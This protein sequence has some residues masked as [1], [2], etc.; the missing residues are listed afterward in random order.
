[1][2][3]RQ[4]K[5]QGLIS[6]YASEHFEVGVGFGGRDGQEYPLMSYPKESGRP[7]P[8]RLTFLTIGKPLIRV[9]D[10]YFRTLA[11]NGTPST[12][13]ARHQDWRDI[14]EICF[15]NREA[16]VGRFLRRQLA[17]RDVATL[18]PC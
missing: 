16:D 9:G 14:V 15:D 4:D 10:V 8:P 5:V 12:S 13:A 18:V 17:T 6:K 2:D 7:L 11:A 3:E 1:M